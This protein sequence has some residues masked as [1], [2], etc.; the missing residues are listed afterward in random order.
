MS[1]ALIAHNGKKA[2]TVQFSKG[3]SRDPAFQIN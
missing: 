1:I 3:K 2:E